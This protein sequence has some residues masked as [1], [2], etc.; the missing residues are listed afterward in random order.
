MDELA[1]LV[2][3][4]IHTSKLHSHIVCFVQTLVRLCISVTKKTQYDC[5]LGVLKSSV[6]MALA[7]G[8]T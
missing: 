5:C 1:E 4:Q 2:Y 8:G 7:Q 6:L 3:L